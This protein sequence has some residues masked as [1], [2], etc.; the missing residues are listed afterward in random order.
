M[1]IY[2]ANGSKQELCAF[3]THKVK[4]A[5]PSYFTSLLSP[6]EVDRTDFLKTPT[7]I[8]R[9]QLLQINK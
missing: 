1:V 4:L 3:S 9:L 7:Q 8:V 2:Q 6:H 5:V